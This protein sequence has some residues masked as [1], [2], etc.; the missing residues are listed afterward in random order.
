MPEETDVAAH[1]ARDG[2]ETA[3]LAGLRAAGRD[4]EHL[5]LA[6]LAPVDEF[7]IGGR[8]ATEAL[9]GQLDLRPGQALLDIGSGLGGATRHFAQAHGCRAW[10]VDLTADFVAVATG[11][12]QR[13]GLRDQV[14][15][16]EGSALALPF[17]AETFDAA[18]LLHVGMNIADKPALF[19]EA[20][21]VLKPGAV[22]G[23][24]DVMRTGDG[25][26][27]YPVP[28]ATAAAGSAL[29]T[30][31]AYRRALA[32]A[33]FTVTAERNRR[34]FAIEF[35]RRQRAWMAEHGQPP[36]GL[37]LVMGP[38][39]GRKIAHLATAIEAGVVAPVEMICRAT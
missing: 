25:E 16:I 28:W 27:A 3:I 5:A 12:A 22:F 6:D 38:E 1:Y 30:P 13:V 37:H 18:T 2:L 39:A 26:P 11:L 29:A 8:E 7:H 20:R 14:R 15:Y 36:L 17:P 21:R 31:D 10:G 9:A 4:P 32:G 19:A 34:D 24:Y 33:G 23:I 35:F